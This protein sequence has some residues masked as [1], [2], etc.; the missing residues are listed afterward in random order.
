MHRSFA[1]VLGA[2]LIASLAPL[3]ALDGSYTIRTAS[4]TGLDLGMNTYYPAGYADPANAAKTYPLFVFLGGAGETGNPNDTAVILDRTTRHGPSR[5]VVVHGRD[6]PCIVVT[7]CT[8]Q[9]QAAHP[10]YI[11]AMLQY[12]KSTERIDPDRVYFSGLCTGSGG[13]LEYAQI[14]PGEIAALFPIITQSEGWNPGRIAKIPMWAFHGYGDPVVLR[15][16]TT[17]W[18]NAIANTQVSSPLDCMATYPYGPGGAPAMNPVDQ[19][20]TFR[21]ASGWSWV[22]GIVPTPDTL[23]RLTLYSSTDHDTWNRTITDDTVL[24][25]AF[26]QHR[27][28]AYAITAPSLPGQIQAERFD[29]G[30]PALA[31][32]DATPGNTGGSAARRV[33]NLHDGAL[34]D[35]EVDLTD[36]ADAGVAV[37]ATE[38]GEWLDYTVNAS[39][40]TYSLTL[41]VSAA[42]PGSSLRFTANG[43]ALTETVSVPASPGF[44]KVVVPNVTLAPGVQT[45]RLHVVSGGF[46]LD[47][48][49]IGIPPGPADL[50]VD[51]LDS[52]RVTT[53]G[54]W[55]ATNFTAGYYASNYLSAAPGSAIATATFRPTLPR[56]G[57]YEVFT[58]YPSNSSRGIA[59]VS[60]QHAA[61]VYATQVDQRQ[62]GG[63]WQSVGAFDFSAG[64]TGSVTISSEGATGYVSADA[65][66]F[67]ELDAPPAIDLI[68]DNRDGARVT[69]TGPWSL[70]SFTSGYYGTDYLSAAPGSDAQAVY[71]P[72]LPRA[73]FFKLYIQYP[74]NGSR[75]ISPV[76]VA[77]EDGT[78]LH[79]ASVDQRVGGG[80]WNFIGAFRFAAGTGPSVT[81]RS[82]G[83]GGY[84]SADAIRFEQVDALPDIDL[85]V[86]NRDGAR[87]TSSGPWSLTNFTS[88]Y[89]GVDYLSA[90]PGADCTAVF[91]PNLTRSGFFQVAVQYPSNASRGISPI[92]V[93]HED[94]T[95]LY[96]TSVDQRQSGG[97]WVTI[98][99]F[100]F[101]AGTGPSVTIRSLGAGGYVS[102]DAV[103]F[104]QIAALPSIDLIVD[105]TD[106]ARVTM[107]GG[108]SATTSVSGYYGTNY[109]STAPGVDKRVIFRPNLSRAATLAVSIW[110]PSSPS[111]GTT[112]VTIAYAD[113]TV[114]SVTNVAQNANGGQWRLLGTFP[115]E[116]GSGPSVTIGSFASGGWI[117]A[118]AIR[119]TETVISANN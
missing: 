50:I 95:V 116:P 54:T 22:S 102:A 82:L 2:L 90:A 112:P 11:H 66:R 76:I 98:G 14:H 48:F 75:G 13:V 84:V 16:Q 57:W 4:S 99:S 36:I 53:T 35:E 80:A 15:G 89:Y 72:N 118:D 31:Y 49:E 44:I 33:A 108:W 8:L 29:R 47:W 60:V 70:T 94:G 71:R 42:A 97:T 61:G 1:S 111:R 5:Q 40:G 7:P 113:G 91:R 105:N 88:G 73:G 119:F 23:L 83:A 115:F 93:G 41:R 117:S 67:K 39:S 96:E 9:L 77:H 38:A 104:T 110:Y 58:Q 114:T 86:D 65:V 62:G 101:D 74:S 107:I 103:R 92:T 63:S 19:T 28:T 100:R 25:W 26:R 68:V 78:S 59:K 85:I 45:L 52:D 56:A 106:S 17:D 21:P 43:E 37:T 27:K 46:D 20:G 6:Y 34:D 109:V 51:N 79:N 64:T 3:L 18:V 30:G 10:E 87:V 32:H 69:S 12:L 24:R 55:A 81:I